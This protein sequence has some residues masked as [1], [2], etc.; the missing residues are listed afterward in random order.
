MRVN[1][2]KR[3]HFSCNL[4]TII[5]VLLFLTMTFQ[6][7]IHYHASRIWFVPH[8][9]SHD[10]D[11]KAINRYVPQAVEDMNINGTHFIYQFPSNEIAL[12]GI[13]LI[14]HAC[15]HSAYDFWPLQT[16]CQHCIGLA[17]EVAIVRC[18]LSS[19]YL[20][21]AVS[22]HDRKSGC[23]GGK[24]DIKRVSAVLDHLQA[25]YLVGVVLPTFAYGCSSGGAFVWNLAQKR[26]VSGIIIQVM[27]VQVN[28]QLR[29]S[30]HPIPVVFNSMP[31]DKETSKAMR[32]SALKLKILYTE[33]F[34]SESKASEYINFKECNPIPVDVEYLTNR[35]RHTNISRI[36]AEAIISVLK[37]AGYVDLNSS[38][39]VKDPTL[40]H[41]D[42]RTELKKH[43]KTSNLLKARS[44]ILTRGKSP[45]AKALH[46]CWAFHEYC[47]DYLKDDLLWLDEFP[48]QGS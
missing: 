42:W 5:G 11:V 27:P 46:R 35:L 47:S 23:W 15:T 8:E 25:M 18:A 38:Y 1:V 22:S 36:D 33:F 16:G 34:F 19:G 6:L 21:V 32:G 3:K 40:L 26:S 39:L 45:L 44:I 48:V 12:K 41:N 24:V 7:A 4:C 9:R 17:E 31:R 43:P 2:N 29:M 14:A 20:V 10:G 37:Q 13:F 30:Q 28:A